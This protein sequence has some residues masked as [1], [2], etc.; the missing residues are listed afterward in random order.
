MAYPKQK[1]IGMFRRSPTCLPVETFQYKR[2]CQIAQIKH[3]DKLFSRVR[4]YNFNF[5]FSKKQI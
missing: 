4:I 2:T 3:F 1:Y 5:C